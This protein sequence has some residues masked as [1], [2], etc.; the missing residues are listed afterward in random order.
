MT[1]Y[2]NCNH[3]EY[4]TMSK[5]HKASN[6]NID[7]LYLRT[8]TNN[9]AT[10][11]DNVVTIHFEGENH[12]YQCQ[13]KLQGLAIAVQWE[14]AHC[15]STGSTDFSL[16]SYQP[17]TVFHL[18]HN[19]SPLSFENYYTTNDR[20]VYLFNEHLLGAD[21]PIELT[22]LDPDSSTLDMLDS[23]GNPLIPDADIHKQII[24]M[25]DILTQYVLVNEEMLHLQ[26]FF[27]TIDWYKANDIYEAN[28]F[29]S[30]QE[31]ADKHYADIKMT[32]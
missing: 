3:A 23:T 28:S 13:N 21:Y 29:D 17:N 14:T 30:V 15:E 22:Q 10:D 26:S 5:T 18:I 12:R 11:E 6:M 25:K 27:S 24:E 31:F 7:K 32:W 1:L 2:L 20:P 4:A 9:P 8:D 16:S 19:D